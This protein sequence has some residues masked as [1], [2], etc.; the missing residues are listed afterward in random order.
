MQANKQL[1]PSVS[2]PFLIQPDRAMPDEM[3][4]VGAGNI[5]PDIA[6]FLRTGL[7]EKKLY[8]VDVA[9]EPLK[10]AEKRFQR[11][12]QKGID[13]KKMTKEQAEAVLGNIVYTTDYSRLA[14]CGLVIEAA[15]EN[16]D[17]KR[18][19]FANLEQI[20][21]AKAILTSNTSSIP[22]DQIFTGLQHPERN[23]ITHFFA[24][25]WRSMAVEVINW[26]GVQPEI[27]DF[28][29]WFFASAG[30]APVVTRNVYSFLLNRIFENWT[31]EAAYLVDRATTLQID[32]VT[33]EFVGA[34]P[35]FVLDMSG[36]NPLTYESQTRRMAE[37]ACYAPSPLLLSVGKWNVAKPGTPVK[38][39]LDLKEWIRDRML[40][41]IFSQ[42]FD[43]ADRK[44]GTR[45]DLNFGSLI[46][47]GFK[48]G[49]F[50]IMADLG[51]QEVRRIV[52]QF[53]KERPGFPRP[54]GAV[55]AYLDFPRDILVDNQDGVRIIT[56]RRPQAANA[57]GAGTCNEILAELKKGAG[58]S[59]VKGFV[60]TGY[61]TKAFCAGADI[62][63]FIATF[64]DREAGV[65][66]ARGNSEVLHYIDRMDKPVVAAVNGLAM[67]GGVELA[68]RCHS[69]VADQ[70][71]F[72]QLPEITLG[73]L[74]GMGG[75]V[76][77]YRKWPHASE[78]FHAMIGQAQRL[79]IQE[80]KE[81]GM[82]EHIT[83][84]Y[85]ELIAA[86]IAE[87]QRLQGDI[88]RITEGAV[89]ISEFTVPEQPMAGQL[90]LSKQ[91]L[92]I[93]ARVIN[94]AAAANSL[95]E[96]L[97]INYQGAGEISCIAAS[98]EGVNAFLQ[99]RK[100]VF[101]K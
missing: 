96:A 29:L 31:N 15:T 51:E 97:E 98:K 101:S 4:V 89:G 3:A 99:K 38:V 61:G 22:A 10:N 17:L 75:A 53:E 52:D 21:D 73:I 44:I 39:P 50:D 7:P 24:P 79:T 16:L 9:E 33:E 36:G 5:G 76:I 87:V 40:G 71:A 74:P 84:S 80:A 66:L 49:I 60:I 47:L 48:K 90:A 59:S 43:I 18:K 14:G 58:D 27:I 2:N 37:R 82:L 34:G 19:I 69:M 45:S 8:L 85:P 30:K 12:A 26:E 62:G 65:A 13:Y 94:Q 1:Y 78:T 57:L 93:F 55:G 72:F 83:T 91:A 64:D 25:A 6:Y 42:C 100:P 68:M 11:Y 56:I 92:S 63:G 67:G 54:K 88:P 95:E 70:K 20:V 28:L 77:P 23:T 35:F 46:G 81:L 32:S 86:A 41:V